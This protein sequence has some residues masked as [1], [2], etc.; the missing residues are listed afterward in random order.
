MATRKYTV[1]EF[2]KSLRETDPYFQSDYWRNQTDRDIYNAGIYMYPGAKKTVEKLSRHQMPQ[3][4][5]YDDEPELLEKTSPGYINSMLRWGIDNESPEWLKQAWAQSVKGL[6]E[7]A[8]TGSLGDIEIDPN[9][10]PSWMEEIGSGLMSFAFPADIATLYVTGG[11]GK[12]ATFVGGKTITKLGGQHLIK[13]QVTSN[14]AKKGMQNRIIKGMT[15][16]GLSNKIAAD[17]AKRMVLKE[18]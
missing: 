1:D 8:S 2:V 4:P 10:N 11:V 13:R 14:L 12:A 17:V 9:W 3:A 18:D 5:V 15:D 16:Y 6:A 7:L